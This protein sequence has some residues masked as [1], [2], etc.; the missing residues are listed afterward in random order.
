MKRPAVLFMLE[1]VLEK[2]SL[3]GVFHYDAVSEGSYLRVRVCGSK[4]AY[5]YVMTLGCRIDA[6]SRT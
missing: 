1:Y 5:L 4:K 6:N 2:I 3:V